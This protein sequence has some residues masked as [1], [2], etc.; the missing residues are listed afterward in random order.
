MIGAYVG[1]RGVHDIFRA[2]DLTRCC[3]YRLLYLPTFA[4]HQE[5]GVSNQSGL[6]PAEPHTWSDA[7]N[8]SSLQRSLRPSPHECEL[9]PVAAALDKHLLKAD[10][11]Q[12]LAAGA[13][14]TL[15]LFCPTYSW[16]EPFP[17]PVALRVRQRMCR[18]YSMTILCLTSLVGP[19]SLLNQKPSFAARN[20]FFLPSLE[21]ID[22][23]FL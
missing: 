6:L 21:A 13:P 18:S 1:S 16:R 20:Y 3:H 5:W 9:T 10:T 11:G 12:H 2:D 15:C 4:Q 8:E 17:F 7:A 23:I 14:S 22:L 19:G